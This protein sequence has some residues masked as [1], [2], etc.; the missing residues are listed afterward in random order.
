MSN[1]VVDRLRAFS[2]WRRCDIND[3][4]EDSVLDD[5]PFDAANEIDR[6]RDGI[7]SIIF[8]LEKPRRGQNAAEMQAVMNM[9]LAILS[10]SVGNKVNE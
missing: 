2:E 8:A 4:P 6:L 5:A 7:K 3:Y 9:A 10:F 1:D